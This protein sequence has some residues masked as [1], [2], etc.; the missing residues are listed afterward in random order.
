MKEGEM[1]EENEREGEGEGEGERGR[2]GE[3]GGGWGEGGKETDKSLKL[4]ATLGEHLRFIST[5]KTA[6]RST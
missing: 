4:R 3:G 5:A 6:K 2:E 1:E